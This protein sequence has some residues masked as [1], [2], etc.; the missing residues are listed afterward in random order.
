MVWASPPSGQHAVWSAGQQDRPPAE[1]GRSPE[2]PLDTAHPGTSLLAR[3]ER[4]W[5]VPPVRLMVHPSPHTSVHPTVR[6]SQAHSLYVTAQRTP[7]ECES[8]SRV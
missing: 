8:L 1:Q 4:G 5:A 3:C 6:C 2:H 7:H